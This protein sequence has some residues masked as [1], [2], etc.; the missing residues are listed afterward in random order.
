MLK[1][2][3]TMICENCKGKGWV[4][5]SVYW[6]KKENLHSSAYLLHDPTI[7]CK[8]CHGS[9]Y[10]IGNMNDILD[11]LKHLQVKFEHE[12]D[13]EYLRSTKQCIK[14]IEGD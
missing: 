1:T 6:K 9:G 7:K 10:I 2:V 11:F 13:K 5:N 3:F 14:A 8:K 4:D 12:N